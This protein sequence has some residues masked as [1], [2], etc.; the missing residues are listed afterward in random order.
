M[1]FQQWK[2]GEI[3]LKDDTDMTLRKWAQT[4]SDHPGESLGEPDTLN[5]WAKEGLKHPATTVGLDMTGANNMPSWA[6]QGTTEGTF[7]TT[8]GNELEPAAM[9]EKSHPS[10]SS[11]GDILKTQGHSPSKDWTNE[12][13]VDEL[14]Y[15][16]VPSTGNVIKQLPSQSTA[17]N[18]IYSEPE[19]KQDRI[20][21]EQSQPNVGLTQSDKDIENG[22][23]VL[24]T[25]C[26]DSQT[27]ETEGIANPTVSESTDANTKVHLCPTETSNPAMFS[28]AE[29]EEMAFRKTGIKKDIGPLS[30]STSTYKPNVK[31]VGNAN[32][33]VS[34][35]KA[36]RP[37]I[38]L[39]EQSNVNKETEGTVE[40]KPH[41]KTT[42]Y[43][44]AT[45][46]SDASYEVSKPHVRKVWGM[47][48]TKQSDPDTENRVHLKIVADRHSSVESQATVS[49]P[50]LKFNPAY[51]AS[52]E[53]IPEL[54]KPVQQS[55]FGHIS[56]LSRY[57]F[58][59]VPAPKL[60]AIPGYH[61]STESNTDGQ[62][63]RSFHVRGGRKKKVDGQSATK[64]SE[65]TDGGEF[66]PQIR[67]HEDRNAWKESERVDTDATRLEK[68]KQ[69]NMFGHAS[70]SSVERLLYGAGY[71]TGKEQMKEDSIL[72]GENTGKVYLL[73]PY[74]N[75]LNNISSYF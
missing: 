16:H 74:C 67:M 13:T 36:S 25:V 56:Q 22:R 17:G 21:R 68:F 14:G 28:A 27:S 24:L 53:S 26:I 73:I 54:P 20:K 37:S 30:N 45:K 62:L 18:L 44:S 2:D 12:R 32:K 5:E 59:P 60:R 50:Q 11:M 52:K 4:P 66:R 38:K 15:R 41:I 10:Q 46:E 7:T 61:A 47:S 49:K 65:T 19:S 33:D 23:E 9:T 31:V 58:A 70:H 1:E 29:V 72:E 3:Q 57:E 51:Y 39:S 69:R 42:G 64:E 8:D 55:M 35:Q 6:K 75:K 71:G 34:P 63:D 40:I 43:M 48:S